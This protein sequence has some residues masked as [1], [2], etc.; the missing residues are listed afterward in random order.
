MTFFTLLEKTTFRNTS[1]KELPEQ[2]LSKFEIIH[3]DKNIHAQ[4]NY[5]LENFGIP[6]LNFISKYIDFSNKNNLVTATTTRFNILNH[7]VILFKK[8]ANLKR[9]NDIRFLNKF[10]ETVNLKLK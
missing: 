10:F 5:I 3:R 2:V 8:I 9:I 6:T 7:P 1:G 4:Q